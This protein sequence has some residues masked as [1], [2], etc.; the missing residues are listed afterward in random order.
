MA[1]T[2]DQ[3]FTKLLRSAFESKMG[4]YDMKQEKVLRVF[5]L[6]LQSLESDEKCV[7]FYTTTFMNSRP[8]VGAFEAT[9]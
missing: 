2:S 7:D 3:L 9:V 5:F 1:K 6:S 8:K 4:I